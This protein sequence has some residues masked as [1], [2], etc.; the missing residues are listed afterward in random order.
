MFTHIGLYWFSFWK[1][2]QELIFSFECPS[3]SEQLLCLQLFSTFPLISPPL[4]PLPPP[5]CISLQIPS[6]FSFCLGHVSNFWRCFP[7][8][9]LPSFPHILKYAY[10]L[11][12]PLSYNSF[13]MSAFSPSPS[14]C[15]VKC[16]DIF[17][18]VRVIYIYLWTYFHDTSSSSPIP[19][20]L[21]QETY[22]KK[23]SFRLGK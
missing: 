8:D 13:T 16:K 15:A 19:C 1:H 10:R 21:A 9:H 12:W 5:Q 11:I 7:L 17:Q 2:Q 22:I 14:L 6:S 18:S 4:I 3:I 23:I 20:H